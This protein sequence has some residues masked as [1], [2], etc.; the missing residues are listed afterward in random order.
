MNDKIKIIKNF[1]SPEEIKGLINN[2]E[3][4]FASKDTDLVHSDCEPVNRNLICFGRDEI[5]EAEWN[6]TLDPLKDR[7]EFF[8]P[9]LERV[10]NITKETFN[11][12]GDVYLN[13]VWFSKHGKG[14]EVPSHD[15]TDGEINEQF[16]YSA[17]GYLNTLQN[18]GQ[19]IFDE[20]GITHFPEA[21]DLVVFLSTGTGTHRVP[22]INSTRY[23]M[24]MWLT[25]NPYYKLEL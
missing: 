11:D 24:P 13:Q 25:K 17:V 14:G 10:I 6:L 20:M 12:D 22:P 16:T 2:F 7:R 18:S 21:G 5:P 4:F 3:Y 19:I 15:D 23:T 9:I 8:K 1:F